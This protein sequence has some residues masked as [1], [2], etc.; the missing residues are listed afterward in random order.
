MLTQAEHDLAVAVRAQLAEPGFAEE[1]HTRGAGQI[2]ELIAHGLS[3]EAGIR[4]SE[5][6]RF[7]C[8]VTRERLYEG[9]WR[10]VPI[11]WRTLFSCG[12]VLQVIVLL[13]ELKVQAALEMIDHALLMGTPLPNN[14]LHHVAEVLSQATA[15]P[16]AYL[17]SASRKHRRDDDLEENLEWREETSV[18]TQ[19]LRESKWRIM[20]TDIDEA[21]EALQQEANA[22]VP[23][24]ISRVEL[25]SLQAFEEQFMKTGT[26]VI[27][28]NAMSHWP[29]MTKWKD[30][31][32]LKVHALM[33]L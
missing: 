28:V 26:P 2:L 11:L 16:T 3:G 12:A 19:R 7:I 14:C 29:A 25:P 8:T 13:H 5:L 18:K 32:Y 6:G 21:I 17:M 30:I 33:Y 1:A 20:S 10:D 15:P 4:L 23:T 9:H 27:V 31:S 22:D 24:S